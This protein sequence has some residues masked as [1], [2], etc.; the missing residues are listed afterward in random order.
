M[1]SVPGSTWSNATSAHRAV[2]FAV[3]CQSPDR[4]DLTPWNDARA[5]AATWNIVVNVADVRRVRAPSLKVQKK[6]NVRGNVL[7][8]LREV[9]SAAVRRVFPRG[10]RPSIRRDSLTHR[11]IEVRQ[12]L[13]RV[14]R[15]DAA[16]LARRC[17]LRKHGTIHS[18]L[19]KG[20]ATAA[21][22]L[23]AW[24]LARNS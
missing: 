10:V 21:I 23:C 14:Q 22:L 4:Y 2:K 18:S 17:T 8:M 6:R 24:Q 3:S 16:P 13:P 11:F 15:S 12:G 5:R 19:I 20:I 1:S 9:C 7:R